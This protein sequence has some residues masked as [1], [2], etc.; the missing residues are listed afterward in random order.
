MRKICFF[1]NTDKIDNTLV[2]TNLLRGNPGIGA[3]E[4]LFFLISSQLKTKYNNMFEIFLLTS[5]KIELSNQIQQTVIKSDILAIKYCIKRQID[6][7][8]C[9]PSESIEFY[10]YLS[11]TDLKV[12][13]WSHNKIEYGLA[14]LLTNNKNIYR[15]ICVGYNQALEIIGHPLFNKTE[16]IRN[17]SLISKVPRDLTYPAITYMGHISKSRGLHILLQNWKIIKKKVKHVK[18][19]IIGT[20]RLYDRSVP[21]GNYGIAEESYEKQILK[22]I[23][24]KE[25]K[26]DDSVNVLGIVGQDKHKVFSKT[27]VGIINPYGYETSSISG[28]EMAAAGIPIVTLNKYGQS[29][30][31]KHGFTGYLFSKRKRFVYYILKL[32]DDSNL[33][34]QLGNNA[35][36]WVDNVFSLDKTIEA[37]KDLVSLNPISTEINHK[38]LSEANLSLINRF[39][40]MMSKFSSP[41]IQ[42]PNSLK[43][44]AYY[45]RLKKKIKSIIFYT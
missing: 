4:Y 3:T 11:K 26:L 29:E 44:I 30:V 37:W 14:E 43:L 33:N 18:L 20:S 28:L 23:I 15:N 40:V 9:R 41:A 31:V 25:G 32:L 38:F 6:I 21:I 1:I 17:P 10:D 19:N 36:V 12:I 5:T 27:S 7:L 24:T 13:T 16:V 34:N 42:M 45:V 22:Y 2:F 8:V 35:R 39:D